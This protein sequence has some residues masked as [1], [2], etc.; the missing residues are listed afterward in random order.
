[1]TN[2]N[3]QYDA[4]SIDGNGSD[5][6]AHKRV[7]LERGVKLRES[8]L[9]SLTL[10]VG[11]VPGCAKGHHVVHNDHGAYMTKVDGSCPETGEP[12]HEILLQTYDRYR[13]GLSAGSN[14][15]GSA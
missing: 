12:V 4:T 13:S 7:Q 11:R 3:I 9:V 10:T 2:E 1:M 5:S 14:S 8:E 6:I 15:V